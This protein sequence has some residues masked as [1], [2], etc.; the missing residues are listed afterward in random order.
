MAAEQKTSVCLEQ[1][2][3][4]PGSSTRNITYAKPIVELGDFQNLYVSFQYNR[5]SVKRRGDLFVLIVE[6]LSQYD[7]QRGNPDQA[8]VAHAFILNS[9]NVRVGRSL[10]FSD[11]V[12]ARYLSPMLFI[13]NWT[14]VN[15]LQMK[16]QPPRYNAPTVCPTAATE[17]LLFVFCCTS[18]VLLTCKPAESELGCPVQLANSSNPRFGKH[19]SSYGLCTSSGPPFAR[20]AGV[21]PTR[22]ARFLP[23]LVFAPVPSLTLHWEVM[24]A[25]N[26]Q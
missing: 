18:C 25:R 17:M 7:H 15:H 9:T 10:A 24:T 5:P 16:T 22:R 13:C 23:P 1:G 21:R 6:C 2:S 12:G 19:P 14:L 3:A 11:L 4:P 20:I 26:W 8:V